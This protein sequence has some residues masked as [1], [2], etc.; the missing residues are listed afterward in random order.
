MQKM[1]KKD[2]QR[3]LAQ[4][5]AFCSEHPYAVDK[6]G[7]SLQDWILKEGISSKGSVLEGSDIHDTV[8]KSSS[9]SRLENKFDLV[10]ELTIEDCAYPLMNGA[11]QKE[12]TILKNE[13]LKK[14]VHMLFDSTTEDFR[15]ISSVKQVV[16]YVIDDTDSYKDEELF[17]SF[18][19]LK[20]LE[21]KIKEF[22][23]L[24]QLQSSKHKSKEIL[25]YV[26]YFLLLDSSNQEAKSQIE[27]GIRYIIAALR[28]GKLEH[29][30]LKFA[31]EYYY[32]LTNIQA[33][34][35]I[36][37]SDFTHSYQNELQAKVQEHVCGLAFRSF[38][39]RES[40]NS[41]KSQ[42]V[43]RNNVLFQY[44]LRTAHIGNILNAAGKP[45]DAATLV[46]KVTEVLNTTSHNTSSFEFLVS[47]IDKVYSMP[48]AF[49]LDT[50]LCTVVRRDI[51]ACKPDL[52][53][54]AKRSAQEYTK[55]LQEAESKVKSV[56]QELVYHQLKSV[57][58]KV[59]QTLANACD[60][61][62]QQ[63]NAAAIHADLLVKLAHHVH[64]LNVEGKSQEA[65]NLFAKFSEVLLP[66]CEAYRKNLQKQLGQANYDGH[67]KVLLF[68]K[69]TPVNQ[70]VASKSTNKHTLTQKEGPQKHSILAPFSDLEEDVSVDSKKLF[71]VQEFKAKRAQSSAVRLNYEIMSQEE[72][73]NQPE[74]QQQLKE[75]MSITLLQNA[76]NPYFCKKLLKRAEKMGFELEV[77][78]CR[79]AMNKLDSEFYIRERGAVI[80]FSRTKLFFRPIE[81]Y[82]KQETLKPTPY[83]I[84]LVNTIK[85]YE[86]RCNLEV[87]QVQ[88]REIP[89]E[90]MEA[91]VNRNLF[92]SDV[93]DIQ[94]EKELQKQCIHISFN[95]LRAMLNI[96]NPH[97]RED[98]NKIL[99]GM[100]PENILKFPA[101]AT[102]QEER[103]EVAR[104]TTGNQ[105][106]DQYSYIKNNFNI[107]NAIE[108]VLPMA[109]A[110]DAG[111]LASSFSDSHFV[112]YCALLEKQI[113]N[114]GMWHKV[115]DRILAVAKD[116]KL[117][118]LVPPQALAYLNTRAA[119]IME[120]RLEAQ[121]LSR[122]L[123]NY[124]AKK[125]Y[126]KADHDKLLE[127][128]Q[129]LRENPRL[130][131]Y[132]FEYNR[133]L[134]Q[135]DELEAK[136]ATV[137]SN[138]LHSLFVPRQG[139]FTVN[140]DKTIIDVEEL[141]K[142][143][144]DLTAYNPYLDNLLKQR[145]GTAYGY[146]KEKSTAFRN[147][148]LKESFGM[149]YPQ[150]LGLANNFNIHCDS[151]IEPLSRP[152][153]IEFQQQVIQSLK[154]FSQV[155][156][157]QGEKLLVQTITE[158]SL[159]LN[160]QNKTEEA[161]EVYAVLQSV[162]NALRGMWDETA[163]QMLSRCYAT[164]ESMAI[165]ATVTVGSKIAAPVA[166][167]IAPFI[168]NSAR[169]TQFLRFVPYLS[170]PAKIIGTGYALCNRPE[171][172]LSD[173]SG[174]YNAALEGK[175]YDVGRFAV[176]IGMDIADALFMW[177]SIA[178]LIESA[179][180]KNILPQVTNA[181]TQGTNNTDQFHQLQQ[182]AAK[183]ESKYRKT[184]SF[185]S[186]ERKAKKAGISKERFAKRVKDICSIVN[187]P[188]QA[189]HL[190][191]VINACN[192][193]YGK[194]HVKGFSKPL[195]INWDHLFKLDISKCGK[196]GGL[197]F[198]YKGTIQRAGKI[199]FLHPEE[200][201]SGLYRALIQ[202]GN[203]R[204]ESSFFPNDVSPLKV[205]KEVVSSLQAMDFSNFKP[206]P[207][208]IIEVRLPY[209]DG[210]LLMY[211]N[212]I[213]AE[214]ISI[215]PT[216]SNWNI[217]LER[218]YYGK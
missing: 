119:E 42:E 111:K 206:D 48:G 27:Q 86:S 54:K 101:L 176:R 64:M 201:P 121:L 138:R 217:P 105:L 98:I 106:A 116:K 26:N 174:M 158:W 191:S 95:G 15:N 209:R 11:L 133:P 38:K 53:A 70:Y 124:C 128:G 123:N 167:K 131:Y 210:S 69:N 45:K 152:A 153:Q 130:S 189:H 110:L 29:M 89:R 20:P 192:R 198:D 97:D 162:G 218:K 216:H 214:V 166:A 52:I 203:E 47:T 173:I 99:D 151:L 180:Q 148:R 183:L 56:R 169:A 57:L 204:K 36:L 74:I 165:A 33:D 112:T 23:Q 49:D 159:R 8:L 137:I 62:T 114:K 178:G 14:F 18:G 5:I 108:R 67:S 51:E 63:G 7:C 50:L 12:L 65:L 143:A 125:N 31:Q 59:E 72:F 168:A 30:Y 81:C 94:S 88:F 155:P 122:T 187:T 161:R 175:P 32:A 78:S 194:I 190:M 150:L 132:T 46:S 171:Q 179:K 41:L 3:I 120:Q 213:T 96:R 83:A 39:M 157:M 21:S 24:I 79:A 61:P 6:D 135:K 147:E 22:P 9:E 17:T 199:K 141:G 126:T 80:M 163:Q 154:D 2:S 68:P 197:H 207:K 58:A 44:A 211:I 1:S 215:Y 118:N 102:A 164:L 100:T 142:L 146:L 43:Q 90:V 35:G 202:H 37:Y 77:P 205:I 115:E 172:Y 182:S 91:F 127:I 184:R 181:F 16:D 186:S 195:K 13:P 28:N 160:A 185:R 92:L 145:A 82:I 144:Q 4:L 200:E 60:N 149:D 134:K 55:V 196:I 75:Y 76:H 139:G 156:D 93:F 170:L 40:N 84:E 208:K 71:A 73:I 140:P 104:I 136:L 85:T 25:R 212:S 109:P 193:L 10:T 19:I 177:R 87:S 107:E 103:S 66:E 117:A 113:A 34:K 188:K 129:K